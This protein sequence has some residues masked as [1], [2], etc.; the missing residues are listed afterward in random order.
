[1]VPHFIFLLFG[2]DEENIPAESSYYLLEMRRTS[3][4]TSSIALNGPLLGEYFRVPNLEVCDF[5]EQHSKPHCL[6]QVLRQVPPHDLRSA[7]NLA[8]DRTSMQDSTTNICVFGEVTSPQPIT[9]H[10]AP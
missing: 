9:V 6:K 3:R 1:M 7:E 10:P 8:Q 5:G 4:A 2:M